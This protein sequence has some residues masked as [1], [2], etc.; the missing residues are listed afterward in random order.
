VAQLFFV[1]KPP[2]SPFDEAHRALK[3]YYRD[4][5][6]RMAEE[7][8]ESRES[9]ESP[10]FSDKADDILDKYAKR[11]YAICM[12]N[13]NL[14]QF[15]TRPKPFGTEPISKNEFRCFD[16]GSVIRREDEVCKVCGWSWK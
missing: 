4:L 11:F 5:V 10:E 2:Q 16:C 1:M 3:V 15:V 14:S 7:I 13:Q 9:F 8:V 6:R 12:T